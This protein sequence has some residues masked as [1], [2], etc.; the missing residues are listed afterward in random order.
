[1]SETLKVYSQFVHPTLM[2]VLLA[3]T[4]YAGYTGWQWRRA[5]TADGDLK[6]ELLKQKFNIKHHQIGSIILALMVLGT[7]GGMGATYINGGKL[8]VGP[9][10]LAGLGMTG[11]IATSASLTPY[12]QKGVE[13]ARYSHIAL[14]SLIVGLFGWQAF[15]GIDIV[16][17]VIGRITAA[18]AVAMNLAG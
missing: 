16:Q 2:W 9:H 7:I 18:A 5:R 8:Y 10:L 17:K 6:K 13:W 3:L 4:L 1:M 14:N 11:L 12:M 15:T